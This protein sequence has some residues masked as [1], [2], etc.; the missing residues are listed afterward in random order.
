MLSD[1]FCTGRSK[2]RAECVNQKVGNAL[3]CLGNQQHRSNNGQYLTTL[4][5]QDRPPGF[6]SRESKKVVS[7]SLFLREAIR[8]LIEDTHLYCSNLF[9]S[10]CQLLWGLWLFLFCFVFLKHETVHDFISWLARHYLHAA[11]RQKISF[12]VCPQCHPA[13]AGDS[14][15]KVRRTHISL[16]RK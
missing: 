8:K 6:P 2:R 13:E 10:L 1:R 12:P 16:L 15:S 3:F 14:F 11:N 5:T 4:A 7:R 9:F